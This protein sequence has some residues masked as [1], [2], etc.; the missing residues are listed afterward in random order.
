MLG[1]L[2]TVSH[3]SLSIVW[4]NFKNSDAS[5]MLSIANIPFKVFK[6]RGIICVLIIDD[7][8]YRFDLVLTG[9]TSGDGK[10][11]T[12]DYSK[13]KAHIQNTQKLTQ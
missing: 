12:I 6:F 1:F 5:F 13:I 3:R 10:I 2:S 7:K 9:D 8:E 11:S 4:N